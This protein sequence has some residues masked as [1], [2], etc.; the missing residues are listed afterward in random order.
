[1]IFIFPL[2]PIVLAVLL[3][4]FGLFGEISSNMDTIATIVMVINIIIFLGIII[5]NLTRDT[6]PARKAFSVAVPVVLGMVASFILKYFCSALAAI[7][8]SILG[9]FEFVFVLVVGG[10]I[11]LLL[12][13]GCM[14]LSLLSGDWD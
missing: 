7:E 4:A 13:G 8:F 14:Y 10:S 9:M 2:A 3:I 6:L 11:C 12:V 5:Y 1:M